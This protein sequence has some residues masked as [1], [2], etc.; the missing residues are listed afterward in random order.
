MDLRGGA[1]LILAGF[2]AEGRTE[3]SGLCHIERGYETVVE[4]FKNLGAKIWIG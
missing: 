4:N 3:I 2:L 1:S